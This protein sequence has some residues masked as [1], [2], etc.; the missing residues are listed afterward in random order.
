LTPGG[1]L[2]AGESLTDGARRELFEETGL[3]AERLEPVGFVR[4]ADFEFEGAQY[5]QTETFFCVRAPRFDPV[6]T[7]W[8]EIEHRFLLGH[9]WWMPTEIEATSDTI[10]PENLAALIAKL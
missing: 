3:R 6:A 2:E 4:E 7:N 8:S 9:R 1:G 5:H 10:Y